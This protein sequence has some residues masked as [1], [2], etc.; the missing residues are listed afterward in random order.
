MS[1]PEIPHAT[2]QDWAKAAAKS[3][4]GGDLNA[5]NWITP[6]GIAVKPLYTADDLK[7]LQYT[8]TLPGF[9]PYLRGP[10][11]TMYAARPWTIRQY[12]GFS[13]AEESNAF[14]RKG[15]AGGGQG[16]SR[17]LRPGHAPRL[18]QR[19]SA[20]DGRRRQGRRGDRLRRGHED[21]L[22]RHPA[23]QGQRFDDDERRRAA[24]AGGL[25][26]RRRG[27]GRVAGQAVRD[28]PERHPQGVHGPQHLHLPAQA[29]HA[30]H[31]R[32]H[33]V[34]G[35][36]HAE[37]QL[38]LDLRLSHAGGG[39]QPGAGTGLHAGRRQGVREDGAGQGPG[40]GRVRRAP[41]ASSG[42]SA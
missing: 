18:R 17:R 41:V 42:P 26:G 11:A 4:P 19:P 31:R 9:E 5:L 32:H 35:K 8:D 22:R 23:G 12:A 13:T 29:E 38:D 14:Y 1:T 10:Q 39:R 3:A 28:H 37:V 40:R 30:D 16:V 2:L 36:E 21:P 33:R 24:G 25:R 20:R 27:A 6:D 15:L 34:H 7:G